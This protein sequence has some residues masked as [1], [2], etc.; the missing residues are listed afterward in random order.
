MQALT[1]SLTLVT[2]IRFDLD[3]STSR[4]GYAGLYP[5]CLIREFYLSQ[6]SRAHHRLALLFCT[7]T[8]RR[9][10]LSLDHRQ[11]FR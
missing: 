7:S 1:S 8:V 6:E 11:G 5:L 4:A 3:A 2:V 10:D 9:E